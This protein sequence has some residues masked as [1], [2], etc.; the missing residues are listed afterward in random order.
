MGYTNY[1]SWK[2]P[3]ADERK[4]AAWS[5]D[6]QHLIDYLIAPGRELPRYIYQFDPPDRVNRPYRI[7]GPNG[8]GKPVITG[9][10]VTFNG[11]VSSEDDY[12]PFSISLQELETAN[13]FSFCKTAMKP[14]DLLVMSS[15]V[16]FAH[17]F[18]ATRLWSDGE[19]EA[20][21]IGLEICQRVFGENAMP[22]IGDFEDEAENLPE[23]ENEGPNDIL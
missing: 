3:I 1:W 8:N 9:I 16:R 17:Y 18:P 15:L 22:I 23:Q 7:C 12:E 19:E 4:F 10:L 13:P 20:I 21:T 5:Q 14:Y 2:I 11:D 6:T